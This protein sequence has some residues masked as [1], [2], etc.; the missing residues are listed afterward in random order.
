MHLRPIE[1]DKL[2]AL[3]AKGASATEIRVVIQV[4][5]NRRAGK[6][7]APHVKNIR[8]AMQGATYK[9]AR[10]ETRGRPKAL[11]PRKVKALLKARKELL[12]EANKEHEV[13]YTKNKKRARITV[14]SSV[15]S[16]R[17]KE[18]GYQARPQRKK[19]NRKPETKAFRVAVLSAP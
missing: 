19:P 13:T 17:F 7:N 14:S 6:P 12:A 10:K 18:R 3:A 1:I 9:K 8:I 5:R 4:M 2:H 11:T 16:R 15:V